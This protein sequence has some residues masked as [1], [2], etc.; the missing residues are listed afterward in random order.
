MKIHANVKQ[1]FHFIQI[2]WTR[3]ASLKLVPTLATA[4]LARK[5]AVLGWRTDAR[6]NGFRADRLDRV[7]VEPCK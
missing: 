2:S 6:K 4:W 7:A 3:D 1:V 5:L